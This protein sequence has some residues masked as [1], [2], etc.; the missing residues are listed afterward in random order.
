L[1]LGI[2]TKAGFLYPNKIARMSLQF[3]EYCFNEFKL[4]VNNYFR[5]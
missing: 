4:S 2:G 3:I 1:F 5:H